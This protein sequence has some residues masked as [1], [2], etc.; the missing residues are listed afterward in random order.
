MIQVKQ[1]DGQAGLK[2]ACDYTT[3]RILS[4]STSALAVRHA[5]VIVSISS[6]QA[7]H[8]GGFTHPRA[9]R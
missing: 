8:D 9:R 7:L 6:R 2:D 5:A 4:L 1:G 3:K